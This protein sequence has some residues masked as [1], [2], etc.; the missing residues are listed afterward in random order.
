ME[1][2]A[3]SGLERSSGSDGKTACMK[4]GGG[5]TSY[6]AATGSFDDAMSDDLTRLYDIFKRFLINL[7][8]LLTTIK[9]SLGVLGLV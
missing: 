9:L 6:E 2:E 3:T 5:G 4:G 7:F 1:E 8:I